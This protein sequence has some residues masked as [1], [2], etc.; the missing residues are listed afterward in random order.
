MTWWWAPTAST[1]R[2]DGWRS[3]RTASLRRPIYWRGAL[4]DPSRVLPRHWWVARAPG[5]FFGLTPLGGDLVYCFGQLNTDD[6]V[7]ELPEGRLAHLRAF[8][9]DFPRP[10]TEALARLERDDQLHFGPVYEVA[11]PHWRAGRVLLIGDAAHSCSPI[12]VQGGAM[13]FEDAL[14]LSEMLDEAADAPRTVGRCPGRVRG[15]E[16]TT[17]GVGTRADAPAD[18]AGNGRPVRARVGRRPGRA[19]ARFR[20]HYAPLKAPP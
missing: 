10:A 4:S 17:R 8:F 7:R 6:L 12:M 9:A 16:T 15:S 18:L 2:S 3:S 11:E 19:L 5:R 14:V 1:R 20:A 13:A